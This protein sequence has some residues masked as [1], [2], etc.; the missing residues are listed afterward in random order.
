MKTIGSTSRS[1]TWVLIATVSFAV[2]ATLVLGGCGGIGP[3]IIDDHGDGTSTATEV[4]IPATGAVHTVAG[5]IETEDDVDVFRISIAGSGELKLSTTGSLDTSG[6]L[7]GGADDE[8]L[9]YTEAGG[10]GRNFLITATVGPGTYHVRVAS[11]AL[12]AYSL[13][14]AFAPSPEVLPPAPGPGSEP[15]QPPRQPPPQQPPPQQPPPE[16]PSPEQPP[17]EQP[18]PEQPPPEQPSPEQPSPEQ[19]SPEQPSPEQP[20]QPEPEP[21]PDDPFYDTFPLIRSVFQNFDDKTEVIATFNSPR[22]YHG[23]A[24][25]CVQWRL[26][27]STGAWS[28]T[29]EDYDLDSIKF[30][31]GASGTWDVRVQVEDKAGNL[32]RVSKAKQVT[33]TVAASS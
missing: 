9:A 23:L 15:Q 20:P 14:I 12:G 18:P 16:Q 11:K 30:D 29:C 33:V 2:A 21:E 7:L 4:S 8:L 32:S 1:S 10:N 6:A 13:R 24:K 26:T 28:E 31:V 22:T 25:T 17:P 19:P 3:R 27:T 5:R